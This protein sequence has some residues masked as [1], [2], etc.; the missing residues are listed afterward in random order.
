MIPPP[1]FPLYYL[2]GCI[3]EGHLLMMKQPPFT[4]RCLLMFN[5]FNSLNFTT[6]SSFFIPSHPITHHSSIWEVE[7]WSTMP[8]PFLNFKKKTLL[9]FWLKH[10]SWHFFKSHFHCI[11]TFLSSKF[12]KF[13]WRQ[14]YE[15]KGVL[16]L[17]LQFNFW[18]TLTIC[19]SLYF[20]LWMILDTLHELQKL[21]LTTYLVQLIAIQL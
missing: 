5:F 2:V 16:Q 7:G 9:L 12:N 19:N 14:H 10:N 18:V 11:C 20:T 17:A 8:S 6:S 21:Q 13:K 3:L 15:K 1:P 4:P